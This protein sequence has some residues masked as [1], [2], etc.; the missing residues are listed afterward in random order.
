M[1]QARHLRAGCNGRILACV[2][3]VRSHGQQPL[4]RLPVSSARSSRVRTCGAAF[5]R[6]LASVLSAFAAASCGAAGDSSGPAS[7]TP[8]LTSLNVQLSADTIETGLVA[9]AAAVGF[10]QSGAHIGTGTVAW[11]STSPAVAT[12]TPEGVITGLTP[13]RT[14]LVASSNGMQ[15]KRDLTVIA[16][17]VAHLLIT[18]ET[19][20]L[21][22]GAT[23]PLSTAAITV[24]GRLVEGRP[25]T[26]ATS[27]STRAVVSPTGVVTAVSPGDVV[28]TA[29]SEG[30]SAA[31]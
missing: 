10:D 21:L 11:S 6:I 19:A 7:S 3:R 1:P 30:A 4:T 18:P 8:A 17:V 9:T 13:G 15:G 20:R 25:V 29:T 31:T 16:P 28:V 5:R 26:F 14:T 2:P 23:L 24:N 22:R 12:V 27:D